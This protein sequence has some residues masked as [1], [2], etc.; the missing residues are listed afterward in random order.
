MSRHSY[1]PGS[2]SNAAWTVVLRRTSLPP[3]PTSLL[4]VLSHNCPTHSRRVLPPPGLPARPTSLLLV[5]SHNFPTHSRRVFP[6]PPLP[7]V[8]SPNFPTRLRRMFPSLLP[9]LSLNF[10]THSRRVFPSPPPRLDIKQSDTAQSPGSPKTRW[11][12]I[13]NP[14]LTWGKRESEWRSNIAM[15]RAVRP[16]WT[17]R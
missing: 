3:R 13:S 16:A 15:P 2:Q 14:T 4:P 5:L 10:P 8:L 6:P 11:I 12:H 9:V 1:L 7:L 17:F